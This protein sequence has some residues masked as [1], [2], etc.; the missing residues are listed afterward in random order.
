MLQHNAT[1]WIIIMLKHNLLSCGKGR[2]HNCVVG[3]VQID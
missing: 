3:F 1:G 2:G